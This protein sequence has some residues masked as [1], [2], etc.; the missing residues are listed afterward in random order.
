MNNQPTVH[1]VDDEPA[2]LKALSRLLRSEGF[3]VKTYTGGREFLNSADTGK[4]GCLILDESMPGMTGTE[5]HRELATRG[6]ALS[7]IFL[8]AHGDIPMG[9]RAIKEGA[10]D[11]LV[12]PAKDSELIAC[13]KNGLEK[14]KQLAAEQSLVGELRE[15]HAALSRRE[16]EVMGHVVAG[17]PNKRIAEL[18]GVVEQTIKVHRG[19]AMEKMGAESLAQLVLFAERLGLTAKKAA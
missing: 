6:C 15:R 3:D 4:P 2:L 10:M 8:T 13:I 17:L 12:K 19:R 11:F 14:S 1:I 18:L 16:R 7:V 9:V 5:L